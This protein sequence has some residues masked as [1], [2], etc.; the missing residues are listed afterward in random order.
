MLLTSK[1]MTVVT[2]ILVKKSY[3]IVTHKI[4]VSFIPCENVFFFAFLKQ[5]I[6]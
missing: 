4:V 3:E 6:L 5:T 1:E 2:L